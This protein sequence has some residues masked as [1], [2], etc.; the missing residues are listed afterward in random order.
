MTH[1]E[2]LNSDD[3]HDPGLPSIDEY[4]SPGGPGLPYDEDDS[5]GD[6]GLSCEEGYDF[7]EDL[8]LPCDC[9]G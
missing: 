7:P 3:S 8:R 5:H 1:Q 2:T 9:E 6:P 4:D